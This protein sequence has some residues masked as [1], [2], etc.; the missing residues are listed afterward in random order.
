MRKVGCPTFLIKKK[1]PNCVEC[2]DDSNPLI[3]LKEALELLVPAEFVSDEDFISFISTPIVRE[4][5]VLSLIPFLHTCRNVKCMK[6]VKYDEI[7]YF[8]LYKARI[9]PKVSSKRQ[10]L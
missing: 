7:T 8:W 3:K 1:R 6:I 10:Y 9:S 5:V 2:M 4:K